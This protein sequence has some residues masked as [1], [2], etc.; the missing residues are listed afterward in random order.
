VV[1]KEVKE[2]EVPKVVIKSTSKFDDSD[3][4]KG[5]FAERISRLLA[6]GKDPAVK[7]E[8]DPVKPAVVKKEAVKKEVVKKAAKKEIEELEPVEEK[9][10]GRAKAKPVVYKLESEEEA[11]ASES[12]NFEESEEDE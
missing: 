9:P 4:D 7:Q 5:S 8:T 2:V 12:D 11:S 6:T 3:D 1:K 10:R